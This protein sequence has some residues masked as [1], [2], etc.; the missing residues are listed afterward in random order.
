MDRALLH[1][2]T[3]EQKL[4]LSKL[5]KFLVST[6]LGEWYTDIPFQYVPEVF[7]ERITERY[8]PTTDIEEWRRLIPWLNMVPTIWNSCLLENG[9]EMSA[10]IYGD[11]DPL[12]SHMQVIRISID[13]KLYRV[14]GEIFKEILD[15]G[16]LHA[17]L[18]GVK[19]LY[20]ITCRWEA[21]LRK[22]PSDLKLAEARVLEVLNIK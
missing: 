7:I 6:S 1:T 21:F 14:G 22:C 19:R 4:D 20:F 17:R 5:G 16:R 3:E 8:Y 10:F 18:L 15:V 11:W 12:L 2:S 9:T 13:P